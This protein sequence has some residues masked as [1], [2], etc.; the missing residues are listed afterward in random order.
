MHHTKK[1]QLEREEKI[2]QSLKKLDYLS[3]SQLQT[4]HDLKSERN[5]LRVMKQ[6]DPYVSVFR[7]GENIY[8]LNKEGRNRTNANKVRKRTTTVN[9]Y[10]MRNDLYIYLNC[11]VTWKNEIRIISK[12]NEKITAVCDAMFQTDHYC[13]VEVDHTQTMKK[14]RT[15]IKKYRRLIER[16][17]FKGM[18]T[19]YWVTITEHRKK[20]LEELCEGLNCKVF[21]H[22]DLK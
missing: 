1:K 3:R 19:L 5:T 12:G 17:V 22:H 20:V 13:L 4:M 21:L 15:K 8:Y 7:D 14:N 2:L 6:I 9:H 11:P 10:L 16:N 18:P